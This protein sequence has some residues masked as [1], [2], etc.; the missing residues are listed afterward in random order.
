MRFKPLHEPRTK[1]RD[2][3]LYRGA[4]PRMDLS[5]STLSITASRKRNATGARED[6]S[7][8][9]AGFRAMCSLAIASVSARSRFQQASF[10]STA[11]PESRPSKSNASSS[12]RVPS[13]PGAVKSFLRGRICAGFNDRLNPLFLIGGQLDRHIV[14]SFSFH[15]TRYRPVCHAFTNR[16][17]FR[18]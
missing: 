9:R 10:V 13:K 14:L 8:H 18:N 6:L 12:S 15:T 2:R 4:D 7:Y 3:P 16:L 17:R 5:C 11:S 1:A